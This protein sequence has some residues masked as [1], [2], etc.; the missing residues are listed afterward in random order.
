RCRAPKPM[1][2]SNDYRSQPPLMPRPVAFR[3]EMLRTVVDAL[4]AGST[5]RAACEAAGIPWRT[6]C[7][8]SKA[9]RDG[10]HP[11]PDVDGLV[12][13]ARVAY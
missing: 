12:S 1:R 4:L 10:G 11:D 2:S 8:W 9:H 6:W 7:D 3:P 5:Y 13:A